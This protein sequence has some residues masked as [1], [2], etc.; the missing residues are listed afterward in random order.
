MDILGI[1]TTFELVHV[2][3]DHTHAI[4]SRKGWWLDYKCEGKPP[5]FQL[6]FRVKK[7]L[8]PP[9]IAIKAQG[10]QQV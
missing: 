5:S 10:Y 7:G 8:K 4:G 3:D 2:L 9:N 6:V 1:E